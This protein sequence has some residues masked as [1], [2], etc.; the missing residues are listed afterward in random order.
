MHDCFALDSGNPSEVRSLDFACFWP[1][2]SGHSYFFGDPVEVWA[3]GSRTVWNPVKNL[4]I[5]VEVMWTQIHQ[6]MQAPNPA[7]GS[8]VTYSFGG[9][10]NRAGALYAPADEG[11]WSGLLRVQRNFWP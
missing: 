4:D 3:V 2:A 11:M 5:G 1:V 6:H 9:G 7:T 10:G 8:G